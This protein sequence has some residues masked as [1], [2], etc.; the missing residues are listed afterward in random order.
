M[1]ARNIGESPGETA[2]RNALERSYQP[3]RLQQSHTTYKFW[4]HSTARLVYGTVNVRSSPGL[5][6][7]QTAIF[8]LRG[9][10]K[11][12]KPL[13]RQEHCTPGA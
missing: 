7:C 2:V 1:P 12:F 13:V 4:H 10:R 8:D 11:S 9:L 3:V 5:S 6:L